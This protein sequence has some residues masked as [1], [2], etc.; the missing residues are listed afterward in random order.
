ML[1]AASCSPSG[2]LCDALLHLRLT[3]SSGQYLPEHWTGESGHARNGHAAIY[4]KGHHKLR[5]SLSPPVG[6]AVKDTV[7]NVKRERQS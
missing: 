2:L 7:T 6:D 5:V 3:N 4:K 1:V